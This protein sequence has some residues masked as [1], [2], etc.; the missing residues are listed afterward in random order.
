[1]G[2][3]RISVTQELQILGYVVTCDDKA[4]TW[5]AVKGLHCVTADTLKQVCDAVKK[6]LV[7]L[8]K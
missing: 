8:L 3:S 2:M 1:M 6:D 7:K 5:T 4:G